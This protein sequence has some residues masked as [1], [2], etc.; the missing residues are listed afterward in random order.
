MY[1]PLGAGGLL[2]LDLLSRF[3][4]TLD[5]NARQVALSPSGTTGIA[6]TT[7]AD[8]TRLR[9]QWQPEVQERSRTLVR[10]LRQG[11]Q[12]EESTQALLLKL[13]KKPPAKTTL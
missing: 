8:A 4:L 5:V 9:Q 7:S 13:S 10:T 3:R 1:T 2:G 6:L 11:A 12:L